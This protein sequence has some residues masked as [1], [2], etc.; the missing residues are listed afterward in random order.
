MRWL[1]I[2]ALVM[3]AG[4]GKSFVEAEAIYKDE[5]ARLE[6]LESEIASRR[7]AGAKEEF[8]HGNCI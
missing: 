2:T 7:E 8:D 3:A 1:G 4:C 6:S 5:L